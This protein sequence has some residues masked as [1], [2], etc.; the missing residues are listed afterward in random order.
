MPA[1]KSADAVSAPVAAPAP[2]HHF[3][4]IHPFGEYRRGDVINHPDAIAALKAG[5]NAHH[6]RRIQAQ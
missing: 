1:E 2:E 5:E 4:V 3:V 6:C